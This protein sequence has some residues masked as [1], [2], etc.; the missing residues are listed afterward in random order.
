M[1]PTN[2]VASVVLLQ[3]KLLLALELVYVVGAVLPEIFFFPHNAITWLHVGSD[4]Q[5]ALLV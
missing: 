2:L 4:V 1:M 5:V 3:R